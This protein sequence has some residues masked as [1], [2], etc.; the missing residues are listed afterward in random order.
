MH[1]TMVRVRVMIR[2]GNRVSKFFYISVVV[3]RGACRGGK[4]PAHHTSTELFGP[5]GASFK[6][7]RDVQTSTSEDFY[8]I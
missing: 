7:T 8:V 3:A 1:I 2:V 4:R 5:P 6:L